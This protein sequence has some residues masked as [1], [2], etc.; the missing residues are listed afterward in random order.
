MEDRGG[1]VGSTDK[2]PDDGTVEDIKVEGEPQEGTQVENAAELPLPE[3]QEQDMDIESEQ[4]VFEANKR[5]KVCCWQ[6]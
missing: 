3:S 6:T 1:N 5:V 2:V 4:R